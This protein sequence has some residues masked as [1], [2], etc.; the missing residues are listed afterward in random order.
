MSRPMKSASALVL[1]AVLALGGCKSECRQLSEKLCECAGN[2]N[3]KNNCLTLAAT[4]E[5][6]NPPTEANN[7]YCVT[8]KSTCD[9]RLIDTAK[10]KIRCGLAYPVDG[11]PGIP[12]STF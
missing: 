8:L 12:E 7:A 5:S 11:G 1:L 4:K 9:C 6:A 10:G 2:T 3:E